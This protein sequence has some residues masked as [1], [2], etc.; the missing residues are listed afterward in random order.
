MGAMFKMGQPLEICQRNRS[1]THSLSYWINNETEKRNG[2][3]MRKYVM[4]HFPNF[5]RKDISY[6]FEHVVRLK[7][8]I[9]I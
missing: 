5:S 8:R 9:C 1:M 3:K 6:N 7:G 4:H 2:S